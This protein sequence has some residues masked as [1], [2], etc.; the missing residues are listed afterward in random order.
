MV[1]EASADS[2]TLDSV[3]RLPR[4]SRRSRTGR[5]APRRRRPPYHLHVRSDV[6]EGLAQRREGVVSQADGAQ[7]PQRDRDPVCVLGHFRACLKGMSFDGSSSLGRP[8][9]RSLGR[10]RRCSGLAPDDEASGRRP[11]QH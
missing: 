5:R 9:I 8:R 11:S 4:D 6:D 10:P 2:R 1:A 7:A 3:N